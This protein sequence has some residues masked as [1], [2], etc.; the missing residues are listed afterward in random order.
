MFLREARLDRLAVFLYGS[1]SLCRVWHGVIKNVFSTKK[2]F[3]MV[4]LES[5][6]WCAFATLVACI[7][8]E[9]EGK[10][11]W[12]ERMPT[13]YRTT[14]FV[15][16][17]YGRL[18]GGKPLTGYHSFMFFLPTFIFHAH[19]FMGVEWSGQKELEAWAMYFAWC[20]AWDFYWF[21]LNP[22]YS[23]KF[24]R[25]RV[26]WHNKSHWIGDL[27]PADYFVGVLISIVLAAGASW[28]AKSGEPIVKHVELLA[29]FATYTIALRLA[30]PWYHRWY[31][32]MRERDDRD[33]VNMFPPD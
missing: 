9:A 29:G 26:W 5:L 10:H 13:W 32:R 8:I 4:A 22:H 12:A 25:S 1:W 24:K 2:R 18:M 6:F 3:I 17:V 16:Q 28:V 21:V 15:A 30:A 11:G 33:K 23:G 7:E 20:P 19:F 27:F 31:L 14:G